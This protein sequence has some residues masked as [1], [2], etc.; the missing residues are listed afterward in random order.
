MRR[1]TRLTMLVAAL[2]AAKCAWALNV[3]DIAFTGYASNASQFSFVALADIPSGSAIT[4]TNAGCT[5]VSG[6]FSAT[7]YA[8]KDAQYLSFTASALIPAGTVVVVNGSATIYGAT[9]GTGSSPAGSVGISVKS[10][11]VSL[12]LKGKGDQL[13]AFT[14]TSTT[15]SIIAAIN[16]IGMSNTR[17]ADASSGWLPWGNLVTET[18]WT[19]YLPSTLTDGAN[20]L[21]LGTATYDA[22]GNTGTNAFYNGADINDSPAN[23]LAA[24]ND[25][26]NW[27]SQLTA[28]Y[29]LTTSVSADIVAAFSVQLPSPTISP[30]GTQSGTPSGTGIPTATAT[31]SDTPTATPSPTGTDIQSP[32]A[33]ATAADPSSPSPTPSSTPGTL[34]SPGDVAFVAFNSASTGPYPKSFS[35]LLEQP[36]DAGTV[37]EFTNQAWSSTTQLASSGDK[38]VAWTADAA[39]PAGTVLTYV[40]AG[41][42]FGSTSITVGTT[43]LGIKA[44]AGLNLTAFQGLTGSPA[45]LCALLNGAAWGGANPLPAN[46][47]PGV[48][49]WD[50]TAATPYFAGGTYNCSTVLGPNSGLNAAINAGGV[51]PANWVASTAYDSSFY[52]GFYGTPGPSATASPSPSATASATPS[53]SPS[54]TPT[55]VQSATATPSDSPSPAGTLTDSPTATDVQ[56]PTV[57]ATASPSLTASPSPSPTP[58]GSVLNPGDVAFTAFDSVTKQFSVLLLAGVSANTVIAFSNST[59]TAATSPAALK[60]VAWTAD[61]AYPAGTLITYSRGAGTTGNPGSADKGVISYLSG[62]NNG[63]GISTSQLTLSAFQGST[64]SPTALAAMLDLGTWGTTSALPAGLV[65]GASAWSTSAYFAG[66]YYNCAT[67]SGAEAIVAQAIDAGSGGASLTHWTVA[68]GFSAPGVACGYFGTPAPT[69]TFTLSPTLT[70]SPTATPS[71]TAAGSFTDTPTANGTFTASPTASPSPSVT[72]T[73]TPLPAGQLALGAIAFTGYASDAAQFSFVAL[74]DIQAGT[75]ISFTN[76]GYDSATGPFDPTDLGDGDAQVLVFTA[77]ALIPAGDLVVINGNVVG[78]TLNGGSASAGA[79]SVT[80]STDG[81]MGLKAKGDQ[82]FAFQGSTGTPSLLAGINVIG[83]KN[84]SGWLVSGAEIKQTSYLPS[85]LAA[86]GAVSVGGDYDATGTIG[87]NATYDC[88]IRSGSAT[89]LL[90]ALTSPSHWSTDITAGNSLTATGSSLGVCGLFSVGAAAGSPTVTPLPTATG[91]VAAAKPILGP[92]PQRAGQ[93]VVLGLPRPAAHSEWWVYNLALRQVA[94][95]TFGSERAAW[96]TPG[97]AAGIYRVKCKVTYADGSTY[98]GWHTVALV[99]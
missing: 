48:S 9:L 36:V 82:L 55:D 68:T 19:S 30:T 20:A 6:P 67:V 89:A 65:D 34:L 64:T 22:L 95:L 87:T 37:I 81:T 74:T 79:V 77:G 94:S 45:A 83:A 91:L 47:S 90:S 25:P 43:A 71:A 84:S 8:N 62:A 59:W 63:L 29:S 3:G 27:T 75:S 28:P 57:S 15:P 38:V 21:N 93:D 76:A 18:K 72:V 98:E 7:D 61:Q 96:H 35:V 10:G 40:A 69:T 41:F 78:A 11:G 85:A 56:S 49:A 42:T 1:L 12:G 16:V 23:L 58:A 86:Q 5:S 92:V 88:S 33:T 99:P 4:F 13:F 54:P 70:P 60:A 46:L 51:S 80:V 53:A 14:G 52:C 32:T 66:G 97:V 31:A 2:C 73:L 39:Y 17:T 50:A 44:S 24:I 26:L